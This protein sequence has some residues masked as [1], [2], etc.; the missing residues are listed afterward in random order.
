MSTLTRWE[1]LRELDDLQNR[2]ATLFGR[3]S[4]RKNGDKKEAM[5]VAE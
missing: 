3:T 1:P 5:T 4:V 2:L